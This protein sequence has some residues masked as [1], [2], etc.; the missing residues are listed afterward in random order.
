MY[1]EDEKRERVTD[2]EGMKDREKSKI[3]KREEGIKRGRDKETKRRRERKSS[4]KR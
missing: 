4:G 2:R 3:G 1:K